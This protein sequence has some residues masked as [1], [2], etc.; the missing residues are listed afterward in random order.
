MKGRPMNNRG[1]TLME[2]IVTLAILAIMMAIAVPATSSWRKSSQYKAAAREVV[3]ILRRGRSQ[4]V[5]QNQNTT[6]T[7]DLSNHKYSLAGSDT[8][9]PNGITVEAK[10]ALGDVWQKS[11]SFS[12]TF[13]PQGTS[14]QTIFVRV[15]ENSNLQV[16]VDSTATGLAHM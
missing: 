11:G 6:V 1:F 13:R 10:V 12:V 9:F 2:L 5:Q 8:T 15:N 14:N 7:I 16:Q 3:S 4:A